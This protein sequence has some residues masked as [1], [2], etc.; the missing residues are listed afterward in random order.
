MFLFVEVFLYLKPCGRATPASTAAM[1]ASG[2]GTAKPNSEFINGIYGNS[3][4]VT[5][6]AAT[7]TVIFRYCSRFECSRTFVVTTGTLR[8]S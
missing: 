4:D 1:L 2:F 6:V 3:I 5:D 8:L 7:V